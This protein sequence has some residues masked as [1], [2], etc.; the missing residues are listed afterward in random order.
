MA[1]AAVAIPPSDHCVPGSHLLAQAKYPKVAKSSAPIQDPEHVATVWVKDFNNLMSQRNAQVSK[2]FLHESYWRDLLCLTWDFHTLAGPAKISGLLEAIP[3]RHIKLEIDASNDVRKP[4]ASTF[5][6][7]GELNGVQAFLTVENDAGRG[8]GC[9][10]LLR[11]ATNADEW[12][13]FTLFTSL[14]ELTGHEESTCSRR[15]TGV[16]HGAHV[17]RMNWQERRLA[18]IDCEGPF[19]PTVLVIGELPS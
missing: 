18:E 8:R 17:G 19:E 15:P 1:T 13:V 3:N 11:D 6:F 5:D 10:R 16:E 7:N 12:K 4:K 14:E 9:V 2:M